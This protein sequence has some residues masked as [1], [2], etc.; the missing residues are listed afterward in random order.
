MDEQTQPTPEAV[1]DAT[2]EAQAPP[3]DA[4]TPAAAEAQ[5]QAPATDWRTA[6]DAVPAEELRRH[7]KFAG[8]VGSEKQTWLEEF[9]A[10][11]TE[12]LA[13]EAKAAAEKSLEE[14]AER[15]PVEFADKWLGERQTQKV[16]EQLAGL[17]TTARQDIGR[18]V[19]AAFHAIPEWAEIAGDPEALAHLATTMQGKGA[20]EVIPAWN[21]AAVELVATRRARAI[22]EK[23]LAE[24]IQAERAAWETE[25]AGRGFVTSSRPDLVRGRGVA[26]ADPEPDFRR[27]PKAWN[28]WFDRNT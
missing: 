16:R 20:D 12:R 1:A 7:P 21:A 22:V 15:N 11:E 13:T 10:R 23:T 9:K 24:R 5:P 4:E 6:L 2:T 18:Q 25:A 28:A 19:G 27:D 14:L 17:E 3:V 8:V 26:T